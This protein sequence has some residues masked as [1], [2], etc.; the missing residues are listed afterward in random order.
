M[1]A[2]N[3]DL[4]C[5]LLATAGNTGE[6][7]YFKYPYSPFLHKKK[8]NK[9]GTSLTDKHIVDRFHIYD[10][11]LCPW[12]I[13]LFALKEDQ[14][15]LR[16]RSVS[17]TSN[18]FTPDSYIECPLWS[19]SD[20]LLASILS[21]KEAMCNKNFELAIDDILFIGYPTIMKDAENPITASSASGSPA[22]SFKGPATT[23]LLHITFVLQVGAPPGLIDA[24]HKLSQR[25]AAAI[26]HEQLRRGYLSKEVDLLSFIYDK[27]SDHAEDITFNV[28]ASLRGGNEYL[29]G[30][31][32]P[33]EICQ[34]I[35]PYHSLMMLTNPDNLIRQL[36]GDCSP[37]LV[38]LIQ[39]ISPFR[40]SSPLMEEFSNQFVGLFMPV[41]M[42]EFS[43][44]LR[45]LK[46]HIEKFNLSKDMQHR[47][48]LLICKL[49][50][51]EL[52]FELYEN[53]LSEE[54]AERLSRQLPNLA[55]LT[56]SHKATIMKYVGTKQKEEIQFF[57][58]LCK[59][60]D[61]RHHI[62]DI[63]YWENLPRDEIFEILNRFNEIT[64]TFWLRDIVTI[65]T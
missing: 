34:K 3:C 45:P 14:Q 38:R 11:V 55:Y 32:D 31:D 58:R 8:A 9:Q 48:I 26:K 30:I 23:N 64:I 53:K 54:D 5:I 49:E 15:E 40:G 65:A 63:M 20:S 59:Y 28:S 2:K 61:G 19:F 22:S 27:Y 62:E 56:D 4:L 7:L 25:I 1:A 16:S 6:K 42:S 57:I 46:E 50:I 29:S 36:P 33:D 44:A 13:R 39:V 51:R 12:S 10:F 60:F 37:A 18:N 17:F 41:F 52:N 21:P 47:Y 43:A 24:F 35:Q